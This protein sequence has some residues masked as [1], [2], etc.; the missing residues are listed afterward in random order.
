MKKRPKWF[1]PLV[2]L[3][4]PIALFVWAFLALF[5]VALVQTVAN[6]GK[7]PEW[8]A[9]HSASAAPPTEV[10]PKYELRA[11]E[12]PGA[13]TDRTR[14]AWRR[15]EVVNTRDLAHGAGNDRANDVRAQ[16]VPDR[17]EILLP[18]GTRVVRLRDSEPPTPRGYSRVG[19]T[20]GRHSGAV[21]FVRAYQ[22]QAAR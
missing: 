8:L 7:Q 17:G 21:A 5:V 16:T 13:A 2:V 18:A 19:I 9:R 20:S 6:G 10:T 4:A 15:G 22:V 1:W 3:A 12:V 14:E 11:D